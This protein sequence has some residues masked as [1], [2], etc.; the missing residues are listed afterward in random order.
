MLLGQ[1]VLSASKR[2]VIIKALVLYCCLGTNQ[3]NVCIILNHGF[4]INWMHTLSI[5]DHIAGKKEE[6]TQFFKFNEP[7]FYFN[8]VVWENYRSFFSFT[9]GFKL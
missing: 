4:I 5:L 2:K 9:L 8:S 3:R 7:Q 1:A 6:D